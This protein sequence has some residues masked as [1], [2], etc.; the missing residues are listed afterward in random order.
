MPG[1]VK[2]QPA[3]GD[4][5]ESGIPGQTDPPTTDSPDMELEIDAAIRGGGEQGGGQ[6]EEEDPN[7]HRLQSTPNE[8]Q[9]KEE[10]EDGGGRRPGDLIR[11]GS[12]VKEKDQENGQRNGDCRDDGEGHGGASENVGGKNNK[13]GSSGTEPSDFSAGE[14]RDL[15]AAKTFK[16][17]HAQKGEEGAG[18]RKA[19][20]T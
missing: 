14:V 2:I 20:G 5:G 1:G 7:S 10:E 9:R 6:E 4:T 19:V 13:N 15:S 16:A 8:S 17:L 3:G 12:D 18:K 11:S